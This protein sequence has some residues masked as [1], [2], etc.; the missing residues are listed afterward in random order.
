MCLCMWV[1]REARLKVMWIKRV[2]SVS[3]RGSSLCF[4]TLIP[5]TTIILRL[6]SLPPTSLLL[7]K[8]CS[9]YLLFLFN[10]FCLLGLCCCSE[11]FSS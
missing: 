1:W 7:G 9:A 3:E 2:V 4:F 5:K 11:L 6:S 10:V 8:V